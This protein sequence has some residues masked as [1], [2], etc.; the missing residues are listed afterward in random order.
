MKRKLWTFGDSFT[1]RFANTEWSVKYVEWK[2]YTPK[3]YGEIISDK[4]ELDLRNLGKAGSDYYTIFQTICDVSNGIK[5]D[6]IIIIG[7]SSPLRY[8]LVN[9]YNNWGSII[10]NSDKTMVTFENISE[11]TMNEI[12]VNRTHN[13]Y[14]EEVCS[15]VRLLNY[16]FSKNIIIHLSPF[17]EMPYNY[18]SGIERIG[19]ETN[20]ILDDSHYSEKGHQML[21]DELI[22]MISQ[23]RTKKLI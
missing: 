8:R 5:P 17:Q 10:P 12:S 4:L 14:I 3:V 1:D 7:W 16:K 13:L 15:W 9:M 21:S 23:N 6:D 11:I 22:L 20:G 18:F 2:G 19:I